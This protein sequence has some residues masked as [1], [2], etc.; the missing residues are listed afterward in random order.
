[1][2]GRSETNEELL[3]EIDGLNRENESLKTIYEKYNT[4]RNR[5]IFWFYIAIVTILLIANLG[6]I[7]DIFLHIAFKSFCAPAF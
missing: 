6:A 5:Q 7:I 1:M 4:F 3:I 2:A